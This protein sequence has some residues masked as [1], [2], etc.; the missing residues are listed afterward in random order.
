MWLVPVGCQTL[1]HFRHNP[2]SR[3]LP[4]W[5]SQQKPKTKSMV[6]NRVAKALK[7]TK[8]NPHR[9]NCLI[10]NILQ[11]DVPP[12]WNFHCLSVKLISQCNLDVWKSHIIRLEPL[13]FES[14]FILEGYYYSL[15]ASPH[16]PPL[17]CSNSS[18][19]KPHRPVAWVFIHTTNTIH[20]ERDTYFSSIRTVTPVV[21]DGP[22]VQTTSIDPTPTKTWANSQSMTPHVHQQRSSSIFS[23]IHVESPPY[24]TPAPPPCSLT[25][26]IHSSIFLHSYL[27]WCSLILLFPLDGFGR[28]SPQLISKYFIHPPRA[29]HPS[30]LVRSFI[31]LT[32]LSGV[33]PFE[34]GSS[35]YYY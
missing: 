23:S 19:P 4:T 30:S 16:F 25:S 5:Q 33:C 22:G 29:P 26:Y 24:P 34:H 13:P 20:I 11:R 7:G 9:A 1:T 18:E 21:T 2:Y 6:A 14:I 28:E 3:S 15:V 17:K 35:W 32:R 10:Y 8:G 27:S 31:P 12:N